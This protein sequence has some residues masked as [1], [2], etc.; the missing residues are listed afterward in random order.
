[1]SIRDGI[2][3][4]VVK[5]FIEEQL[6]KLQEVQVADLMKAHRGEESEEKVESVKL[7][8][9]LIKECGDIPYHS[10]KEIP[11]EFLYELLCYMVYSKLGDE[12]ICKKCEYLQHVF[13]ETE[14]EVLVRAADMMETDNLSAYRLKEIVGC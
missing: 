1:M 14:E 4:K 5:V 13:R 2:T 11:K 10:E 6:R 9:Y 8:F 7:Q 3:R 12:D